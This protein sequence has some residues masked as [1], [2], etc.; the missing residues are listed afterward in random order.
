M[1]STQFF[2]SKGRFGR[3]TLLWTPFFADGIANGIDRGQKLSDKNNV[4]DD[5]LWTK[6]GSGAPSVT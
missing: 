2:L 4:V 5:D 1:L 3:N 6:G